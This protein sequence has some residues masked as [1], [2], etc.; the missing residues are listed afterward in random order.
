MV[1]RCGVSRYNSLS[2]TSWCVCLVRSTLGSAPTLHYVIL[3]ALFFVFSCVI[4]SGVIIIVYDVS[5]QSN[6]YI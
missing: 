4:Y 2:S 3:Y 1:G 5:F 6:I